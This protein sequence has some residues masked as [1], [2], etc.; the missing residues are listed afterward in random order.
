MKRTFQIKIIILFLLSHKLLIK[1]QSICSQYKDCFNC[2]ICGDEDNKYCNCA[3]EKNGNDGRCKF[4]EFRYLS[5]WY[6]E[7]LQCKNNKDQS[8]YCS[9][10]DDIYSKNNLDSDNSI[11]FQIQNDKKGNYGKKMLFCYF[12]YIDETADSYYL[13]FQLMNSVFNKP[14]IVYGCNFEKNGKASIHPIEFDQQ[15]SCSST[16]NIFFI[17]LLKGEY[18]SSPFLFKIT[19]K[20]LTAYKYITGFTLGITILLIMICIIFCIIRYYNKKTQTQLL[21]L[22]YQRARENMQRIEQEINNNEISK[23]NSENI[24]ET[25]KEKLDKLFSKTMSEHLYK[26][27]YNQYGGGCSICLENFKKKSIVSIT[28][29]NHVFHF[30]CIKNWLYKNIKNTKCP[31]CNKDVLTCEEKE[32]QTDDPQIIKIRRKYRSSRALNN[33][34]NFAGRNHHISLTINQNNNHNAY[35]I[36]NR[37]DISHSQRQRLGE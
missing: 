36:T 17:A 22:M 30:K 6:I 26:N 24:E 16:Y 28:P 32:P 11:T 29:C 35:N 9:G 34:L 7:L 15:I 33:N 19:L 10:E 12:N 23:E 27:E 4:D 31:N 2:T 1:C 5:E 37:G 20:N 14:K 8:F 3:W 21:F 18:T 13:D 25:N